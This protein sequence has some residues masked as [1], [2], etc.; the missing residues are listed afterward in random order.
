M[1]RVALLAA[2]AGLVVPAPALGA[3]T[4]TLRVNPAIVRYD[5]LARFQ[6]ATVPLSDVFLARQLPGGWTVIAHTTAAT[7]GAFAF[8]RRVRRP[9]VYQA[10]SFG[11]DSAV[12]ATRV[13]P[14]L[15]ARIRG[16]ALR[17]RLVPPAAGR[18]LVGGRGVR[19][20]PGGRFRVRLDRLSAGMHRL[21]VTVRPRPGYV[22]VT[23]LLAIRIRRPPLR[24]GSHGP[25][26]LALKRSLAEQGYALPGVDSG[27]GPA[28]YEAVLAFQKVH[29]LPRTGIVDRRF[30]SVL[31]RSSRPR[32]RVPRGDYLEVSK[33][34]QTVYEV[35]DG[36]V[37]NVI[38]ASTGAT[39]NTPVGTWHVYREV[40]GWD[41]VLFNPMYF[42]RGFAIHGY[43][44]VPPWPASHGCVRVPLWIA[45]GLRER[46]GYGSV[47][48]VYG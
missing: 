36:R 43:P 23:R 44:S 42:L 41:W 8:E 47:V 27:Y 6:G 35:R 17:G 19:L 46:W 31:A 10:R 15:T 29:G 21:S 38:H 7:D 5:G 48:R 37:V 14:R 24:I 16:T 4:I 20:G 34:R 45:P 3:E 1:R 33:T 32:P 26:V 12:V 39:G 13:R 18:L 9:G 30:W 22:R 40:S 11:G 25:N 2:L 28:T